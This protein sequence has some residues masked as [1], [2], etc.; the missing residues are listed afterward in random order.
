MVGQRDQ[1]ARPLRS[2]K[3]GVA[4][5]A[6]RRLQAIAAGCHLD[7]QAFERDA[8]RRALRRA[9]PG[10]LCRI[11]VQAMVHVQRAQ[12]A[13]TQPR[14]GRGQVQQHRRIQA[15]AEGDRKRAFAGSLGQC[16]GHRDSVRTVAPGTMV[17]SGLRAPAR[18]RI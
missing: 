10:P 9:V 17:F 13:R 18:R 11:A 15:T 12:P 16:Q 3:G 8:E 4:R 1:F 5:G 7:V 2:L 14:I 6:C